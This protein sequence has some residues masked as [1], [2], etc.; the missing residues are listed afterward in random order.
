MLGIKPKPRTRESIEKGAAKLRGR[1]RPPEVVEKVARSNLGKNLFRKH[2]QETRRKV[3]EAL[4]ARWAKLS[5]EEQARQ[6]ERIR[7][8]G[9]ANRG[10]KQDPDQ[11]LIHSVKLWGRKAKPAQVEA[12]VKSMRGRPQKAL[13]TK[14][15]PTNK[16]SMRGA[17][18]S[19]DNVVY[20]F[21]NLLDWVRNHEHIF[22]PEDVQWRS[23]PR[24]TRM[25]TP[26]CRAY[27]GLMNL[28]GHGKHVNG[29]WK[30]W[31]VYSH[32]EQVYNSENDLLERVVR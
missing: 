24:G 9:W 19:P 26:T 13:L 32:V 16:K 2:S 17:I 21:G 5:P 22:K 7:Q 30:G 11:S 18:R 15:G 31:T 3:S 6:S 10:K 23:K 20:E 4:K 8:I 25:A 1:K 29:S 14:K 27:K 12:R 28:F